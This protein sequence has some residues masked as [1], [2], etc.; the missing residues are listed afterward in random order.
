MVSS[1]K[2]SRSFLDS[3]FQ[4]YSHYRKKH[5]SQSSAG[6]DDS[7]KNSPS[8]ESSPSFDFMILHDRHG[9]IPAGAGSVYFGLASIIADVDSEKL[10][11]KTIGVFSFADSTSTFFGIRISGDCSVVRKRLCDQA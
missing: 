6:L 2:H 9:Q 8:P 4:S 10:V 7:T 11:G 3:L 1:E 5:P